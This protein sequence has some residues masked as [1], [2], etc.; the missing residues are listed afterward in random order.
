MIRRIAGTLFTLFLV[1]SQ[2]ARAQGTGGA[3]APP[4]GTHATIFVLDKQGAE[5]RGRFLRFDNQELVMLVGKDERRF[6]RDLIARIERGDSLK[7]GAIA[8]AIVGGLLGVFTARFQAQGAGQWIAAVAANTAVY[9]A[10]GTGLDA[11][12]QR[13]TVVYHDWPT[14]RGPQRPAAALAISINRRSK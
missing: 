11:A 9:T 10:I 7:N 12:V 6:T 1:S 4:I 13:R 8:G 2:V 3:V 5:H 14:A